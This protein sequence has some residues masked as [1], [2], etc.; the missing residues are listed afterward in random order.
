MP[1]NWIDATLHQAAQAMPAQTALICDGRITTYAELLQRSQQLADALTPD[2]LGEHHRV[3]I[4]SKNSDFFV[5]AFFA[6]AKAGGVSVHLNWRLSFTELLSVLLDS[7]A[8]TLF[9]S[10]EFLTLA[11]DFERQSPRLKH[12]FMLS[13]L[14]GENT[15]H[16][17]LALRGTELGG[18]QV[19]PH[20]IAVQLYTSGTTGDPKGVCISGKGLLATNLRLRKG[21]VGPTPGSVNLATC[22]L[23]HVAGLNSC[24]LGIAAAVPNVVA[25]SM[26]PARVGELIQQH[27]V[28]HVVGVTSLLTSLCTIVESQLASLDTLRWFSYGGAPVNQHQLDRFAVFMPGCEFANLYGLTE[29]CGPVTMLGPD[30]HGRPEKIGSCGLPLPGVSVRIVDESNTPVPTG[31]AGE[32]QIRSDG[33]MQGYWRKESE[34][35]ASF[36]GDWLR[37]GDVGLLDRDGFLHLKDRLSDM[38]ISGDENVYPQE[39]EAVLLSHPAVD[40][41]AVIGLPDARWGEAVTA[42]VVP[43]PGLP[44][45][46]RALIDLVKRNLAPYK[47]PKRI[48]IVDQLPKN[49]VG[50]MQRKAIKAMFAPQPVLT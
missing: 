5:E 43:K 25:D 10:P 3:A 15:T 23:F 1:L 16:R 6:I 20:D 42:V 45:D 22:P 27:G 47:A 14:A 26:A 30:A 31:V 40:E 48:L 37:T 36:V 21:G 32:I 39:V 9:V 50:K 4:L 13:D 49:A 8:E 28:T 46:E 12:I 19:F 34:T 29:S 44:L 2:L 38:I 35:Q 33:N 7:G 17:A 41:V 18:R 24:L 11:Q